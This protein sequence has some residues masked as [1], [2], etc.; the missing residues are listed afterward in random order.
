M[1]FVELLDRLIECEQIVAR[2]FDPGKPFDQLD[3]LCLASVFETRFLAGLIDQDVAHC[4]SGRAEEMAPVFPARILTPH[5]A[6]IRL[7]DQSRW[8]KRPAGRQSGRP[9]RGQATKL[10]V[11]HR[12]QI[13]RGLVRIFSI[14]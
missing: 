11:E 12:Q 6:E 5:Q 8:L 2:R 14:F 9:S 10:A 7:V 4:L 3:P 1:S 13:R